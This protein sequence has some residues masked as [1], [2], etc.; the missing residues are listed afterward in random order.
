MKKEIK[1]AIEANIAV[2]TALADV[3]NTTEPHFRKESIERVDSIVKS[4]VTNIDNCKALDLGCGTGFMISILKNYCTEIKG[5]DVTKAMLDKVDT[6]GSCNIELVQNDTGTV[7]LEK[8]HYD[9]ATAYT[10]L[11]HL[12]E[13]EPTLKNC[14]DSLKSGGIFYADLSPNGYF[15]SAIKSLDK[16][17]EFD[18][19]VRR[20]LD[21]VHSK[22]EEIERIYGIDKQL[23]QKAEHQKHILG[24][25][26]E[27]LLN[28]ELEKVGFKNVQYIYHWYVGQAQLINEGPNDSRGERVLV[29]QKMHETLIKALPLSKNLFKYIGFIATK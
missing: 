17:D 6:S 24:G 28:K 4:L 26:T 25:F 7:Q 10:F 18:A 22:D 9:I 1:D 15:W 27:E 11:D 16:N 8:N 3:Y 5:V 13:L 14:Y 29:A 19:I 21:A 23:F 20:E 2:H 12:Y